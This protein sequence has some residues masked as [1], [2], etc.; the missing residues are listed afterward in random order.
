MASNYT[1][2]ERSDEYRV[3]TDGTGDQNSGRFVGLGSGK[4]LAIWASQFGDPGAG[5]GIRGRLYDSSGNIAGNEF[6]VNTTTAAAQRHP[7][8]ITLGN[9]NVL[10]AWWDESNADGDNSLGDYRAQIFDSAGQPV[11]QEL[12]FASVPNEAGGT[13]RGVPALAAVTGG[14]L[15]A[16]T[17][18]GGSA[19]DTT[20]NNV[21][22]QL[23]DLTGTPVGPE[24]L[25]NLQTQ[26]FQYSPSA[27]SL[28][29]GG[30][31]I[32][33]T[34]NS[35]GL[36]TQNDISALIVDAQGAP[37]G[38]QFPVNTTTYLHQ[39]QPS[40]AVLTGGGFVVGWHDNNGTPTTRSLVQLF[41]PDG[42]KL[43]GE[44]A[45]KGAD[46]T[47][48]PPR[49]TALPDGGFIATWT[50]TLSVGGTSEFDA[51]AQVF[52][53]TGAKAGDAFIVSGVTAGAQAAGPAHVLPNGSIII[54]FTDSNQPPQSTSSGTEVRAAIFRID[55]TPP[56]V[57]M[58]TEGN[59]ELV[60]DPAFDPTVIKALGGDD[61]IS[62]VPP[63]AAGG[64]VQDVTVD[65]G[66]GTD[67]LRLD[68][69]FGGASG[70]LLFLASPGGGPGVLIDYKNVEYLVLT[71][72]F[73]GGNAML[74]GSGTTTHITAALQNVGYSLLSTGW[75]DD[76]IILT[77]SYANEF[78]ITTSLGNDYID[79]SGVTPNASFRI[80]VS[81]DHGQDVL[82][83]TSGIDILQGGDDSDIYFVTYAD[84]VREWAGADQGYDRVYALGNY[85]LP[86]GEAIEFL[87]TVDYLSTATVDLTG[88]EFNN[89]VIGSNGNNSL[90]GGAGDDYL[91]GLAGMD[92]LDG[93]T[94]ADFAV[95][96]TGDDI[97]YVD[98]AADIVLENAGEGYDAIYTS[99]SIGLREGVEVERIGTMN[100]LATTDIYLTGN[101]FGQDLIAN[102]GNNQLSG[103][104]GN[105]YLVGLD[106]ID[107]LD[108][109]TGADVM[110]G[111]AGGD[112]YYVD[113]AG[114][115]VRE[116]PGGG[117]DALY[118]SASYMLSA[119]APVETLGT[120]NY[121]GT[122]AI[123]LG[124]NEFDNSL[125]G[126]NGNNILTGGAGSDYLNALEG[127]DVV[128]GGAGQDFLSGGAG[129]DSYR[130]ERAGDSVV[131]A[132]DTII[133][134]TSGT[135][136]IDL[137]LVDAN[138]N[139][140][141]RDS[142]TAIGSNAFS[143]KAGELRW[144]ASGS[145]TFV[146]GDTNGDGAADFAITVNT[147]TIAQGDF[148]F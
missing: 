64:S 128:D 18:R 111:G 54:P 125:T 85:F 102:N 145:Q 62:I 22:S 5:Y 53:S 37:V 74:G 12:H 99:S 70:G 13:A 146:Y 100:Y 135:D 10:V 72:I 143:G 94:G 114:D 52:D 134:F 29:G 142:F 73:G 141:G 4:S 31:V 87:G 115:V 97:Y 118:T 45:L 88:N 79:L 93:G 117:Q 38:F 9:G 20:T 71:G 15:F 19:Q 105:D 57:I 49:L 136:R 23:Y 104:G 147:A 140:P 119:G 98:N 121:L 41:A 129:A 68:G 148:V 95:G 51:Y 96:G 26:G 3:N 126:N 44:I 77:G 89:E 39:T 27:A 108:G 86:M 56:H 36:E 101:E 66:E 137:S 35:G 138:S 76:R 106:G 7:N 84:Y 91:T 40:V 75:G 21:K 33:W 25:V 67:T 14:F 82:I 47:A 61:R 1:H 109:G 113:N 123:N 92:L 24:R 16:W 28:P 124:G 107:I 78:T 2:L 130:F 120:M 112:I 80:L 59:D 83:G 32:V 116:M 131:G 48:G 122:E 8:A 17:V 55:A 43:G 132:A 81:S 63:T 110:D 42:N 65:G 50:E 144:E 34:D 90:Y 103:M 6:R 58:G 30:A 139:L 127:N 60:S 69:R 133:D 11:G 46:G